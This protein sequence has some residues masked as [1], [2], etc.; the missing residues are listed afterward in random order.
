MKMSNTS[1][2]GKNDGDGYAFLRRLTEDGWVRLQKHATL[3]GTCGMSLLDQ[4]GNSGREGDAGDTR[5]A[6]SELPMM[7]GVT[8]QLVMWRAR[9]FAAARMLIDGLGIPAMFYRVGL[10][11]RCEQDDQVTGLAREYGFVTEQSYEA[12]KQVGRE[13][14]LDT[15]TEGDIGNRVERRCCL[16]FQENRE[17]DIRNRYELIV[18][19]IS[20]VAIQPLV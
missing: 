11:H 1:R 3:L 20:L 18:L 6:L 17:F 14:Q 8:R 7:I 13:M 2:I 4:Y 15:A 10:T 12:C 16:L 9:H 19:L 5:L